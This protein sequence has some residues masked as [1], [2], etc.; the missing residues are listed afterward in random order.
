MLALLVAPGAAKGPSRWPQ[1]PLDLVKRV[2]VSTAH[3]EFE[4]D[5]VFEAA[6]EWQGERL[7]RSPSREAPHLACAEYSKGRQ[8]LRKLEALLPNGSIGKVSNHKHHGTCFIVTASAPTSAAMK[9]RLGDFDITSFGPIPATMKLAPE[10]LDHDA[11]PLDEEK[12]LATTYG[13]RMRFDSVRGLD[14]A[15]SR[16][17]LASREAADTFT[18][19]LKESVMSGSLDLLQINFWSDADG[20]HTSGP[21]GAVRTWEWKK[22]AEVVRGLTNADGQSPTPGDVCT[23]G[24]LN[25]HYAGSDTL[26]ITGDINQFTLRAKSHVRPTL[27]DVCWMM[28]IMCIQSQSWQ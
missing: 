13:R 28:F 19:D 23:W 2:L 21:A 8:A 16:G 20:D 12:R 6:T 25:V 5:A 3:Q 22:A 27:L 1:P 11:P 24:G 4:S 17:A 7:S 18:V 9:E 14:V 15:L 26:L 10:M